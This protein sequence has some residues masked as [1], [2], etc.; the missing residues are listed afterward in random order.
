MDYQTVKVRMEQTVCHLQLYRPKENNTINDQMIEEC[1]QVL[2]RYGESINLL[3]LEGLPD[4]FCLG[5]DFQEMHDIMA[6]GQVRER[7][8]E[9]LYDLWLRLATGPF[10]TISHVRGRVNAGGMGF[11]AASD[12]VLAERSAQFSLSELL[13][14]VFPAAVLPFLI[15]RMGV[16]KANYMTVMTKTISAEQADEWGLV[17]AC[18]DNSQ[19]LLRKH[20]LRLKPL[21]KRA[22]VR[23]KQYIHQLY[24]PL[25]EAKSLAVE[26]NKAMFS[27][28]QN[29]SGIYRY[30]ETGKFPWE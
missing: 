17:D 23:Y 15:R 29:L 21:T 19:S 7:N 1:H 10:I 24:P 27:D 13:F 25:E 30:I 4:V 12:I 6:S 16:A 26:A 3:V 22:I 20:L 9:R 18:E 8:P 28:P 11:V 2:D 5:A 14:G